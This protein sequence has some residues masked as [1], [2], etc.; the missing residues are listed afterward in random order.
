VLESCAPAAAG[1]FVRA[2]IISVAGRIATYGLAANDS[3][4]TSGEPSRP[5]TVPSKSQASGARTSSPGGKGNGQNFG[6]RKEMTAF[7]PI[8]PRISH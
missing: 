5:V 8:H 4:F 6:T 7:E 1:Q 2:A 3:L